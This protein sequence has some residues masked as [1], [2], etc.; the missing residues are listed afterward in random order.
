MFLTKQL[1]LQMFFEFE[2][3]ALARLHGETPFAGTKTLPKI[4]FWLKLAEQKPKK[5]I[6]K[7]IYSIDFIHLISF[8]YLGHFWM[9]M[10]WDRVVQGAK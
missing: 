1:I 5:S 4:T 7:K 3:L 9:Q 6:D 8:L 10:C 2:V